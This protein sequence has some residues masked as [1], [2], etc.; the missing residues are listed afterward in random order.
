VLVLVLLLLQINKA[1]LP[2]ATCALLHQMRK[3]A[4]FGRLRPLMLLPV[5]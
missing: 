2:A 1:L 3:I 5:Q 4:A